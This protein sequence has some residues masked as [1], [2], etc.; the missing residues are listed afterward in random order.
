MSNFANMFG[1]TQRPVVSRAAVEAARVNV[2]LGNEP[3]SHHEANRQ[4]YA[5]AATQRA[6]LTQLCMAQQR[7]IIELE[8]LAE[9]AANVAQQRHEDAVALSN[10]IEA[11]VAEMT[12]E[13][14]SFRPLLEQALAALTNAQKHHFIT[15]LP[16][17]IQTYGSREKAAEASLETWRNLVPGAIKA[18]TEAL[19]ERQG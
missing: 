13:V 15:S 14:A 4:A 17:A 10:T 7:R 8:A 19:A 5:T 11:L 1:A 3:S 12:G 9:E 6:F 18:L 2:R 16:L